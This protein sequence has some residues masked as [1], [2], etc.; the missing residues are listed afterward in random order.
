[1]SDPK[2]LKVG[3]RVK[4]VALPHE[5]SASGYTVHEESVAFMKALIARKRPS[6]VHRIDEDGYPWIE[7]RMKDG[8]RIAYHEWG[9]HENT[10]W[11][12][13]M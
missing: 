11:L 4:F 7:A 3:D 12:R 13:V 2:K 6:R 5:W 9:I 8:D 10:G 1:M